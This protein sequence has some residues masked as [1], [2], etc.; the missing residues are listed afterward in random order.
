[1]KDLAGWF[2]FASRQQHCQAHQSV[3]KEVWKVALFHNSV[4]DD[5]A[6]FRMAVGTC[7]YITRDRPDIAFTVR[8]ISRFMSNPTVAAMRRLRKLVAY[9]KETINYAV[10]L[11]CPYGGQGLHKQSNDRY[12]GFWSPFQTVTGAATRDTDALRSQVSICCVV[13]LFAQVHVHRGSFQFQAV[14]VSCMEWYQPFVM[15]FSSNVAQSL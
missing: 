2:C 1:M 15:G 8:E 7:L 14:K 3:G 4:G 10:V 11:K 13:T 6:F 12:I 9:L 5:A